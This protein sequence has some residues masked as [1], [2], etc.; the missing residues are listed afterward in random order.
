[1]KILFVQFFRVFV[2]PLLNIFCFCWS[3]PFLSFIEPIFAWNVPL[4]SLIFLK[5]SLV[6]PVPLFYHVTN[7]LWN[8]C[9]SS[10]WVAWL[11]FIDGNGYFL[12]I[13]PCLFLVVCD[14]LWPHALCV[15]CQALLSLG[16]PRLEYWSGL[17]FSLPGDLPG[18]E[19][20]FPGSPE[21]QADSLPA[22]PLG[23]V[24]YYTN[25]GHTS[26]Q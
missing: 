24:I 4:A 1:M 23:V 25:S 12:R 16:F 18:I 11:S 15:T 13:H 10:R 14:S 20:V 9:Q 21:L 7:L 8:W 26:Y 19:L 6:F 2:P 3:L 5:R 22:E 17:P